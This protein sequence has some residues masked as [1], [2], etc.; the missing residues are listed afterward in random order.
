MIRRL[1][2]LRPKPNR[3]PAQR[4]RFGE[5]PGQN[6]GEATFIKSR[7]ERYD[8]RGDVAEKEGFEFEGTCAVL[9]ISVREVLVLQG[10]LIFV[11]NIVLVLCN[12]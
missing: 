6:K 1:S 8:V 2:D 7:R 9:C 11:F 12:G 4:V 3:S 5:E 10:F